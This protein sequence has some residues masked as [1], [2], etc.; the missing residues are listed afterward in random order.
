MRNLLL[1]NRPGKPSVLGLPSYKL[2]VKARIL[3]LSFTYKNYPPAKKEKR[4]NLRT[5][6][7]VY[8]KEQFNT[9]VRIHEAFQKTC[10]TKLT[11]S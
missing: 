1:T 3:K 9:R 11:L 7:V 6:W 5:R 4:N 2:R 10:G 8:L